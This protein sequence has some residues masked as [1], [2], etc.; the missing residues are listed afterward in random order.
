MPQPVRAGKPPVPTITVLAVPSLRSRIYD[1][2]AAIPYRNLSVI[3]DK[4]WDDDDIHFLT[5]TTNSVNREGHYCAVLDGERLRF[6]LDED[7]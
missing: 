4:P 7:V 3:D 2:A 6:V 1:E 5:L